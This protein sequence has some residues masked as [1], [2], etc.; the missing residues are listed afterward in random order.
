MRTGLKLLLLFI[1]FN[2]GAASVSDGY[3]KT[4]DH[5]IEIKVDLFMTS[6]CPHCHKADAFFQDI[7]KQVD[8][9]KVNRHV[10]DKDKEALAFF[11]QKLR[12]L[13]VMDFSVPAM[14]FCGSRWVGFD[15]VQTTGRE[16]L[17]GLSYC[18]QQIKKE[19]ELTPLT[20]EVLNRWSQSPFQLSSMD[21]RPPFLILAGTALLDAFNPCSLFAFALFVGFLFVYP[22]RRGKIITGLLMMAAFALSHYLQQAQ[23]EWYY[24]LLG[25]LRWPALILG[26]GLLLFSLSFLRKI[27]AATLGYLLAFLSAIVVFSYQQTCIQQNLSLFFQQW[28]G[29][30]KFTASQSA[31]YQLSYQLIYL[32]PLLLFL[33]LDLYVLSGRRDRA[34][35]FYWLYS[36]QLYLF[37]IGL[38]L[39]VY[40]SFLAALYGSV[41]L[42]L[43]LTFI[44]WF[45]ARWKYKHRES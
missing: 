45:A 34:Y 38:I 14:F 20:R 8:W 16:L 1:A 24:R 17:K 13:H 31:F 12:T 28:L 15:T 4:N 26:T 35:H 19:G 36:G 9:L 30:E 23:A 10:I 5:R 21:E 39:M 7:E 2:L 27:Q 3:V 32:I 11:N 43:L 18:H 37:A 44:A 40:P 41:L 25:G 22:D 33:L 6:T 42:I 29:A